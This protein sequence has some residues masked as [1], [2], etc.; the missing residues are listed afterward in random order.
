MKKIKFEIF[1]TD[2]FE[3]SLVCYFFISLFLYK[4]AY[5]PTQINTEKRSQK[6]INFLK[7]KTSLSFC[8]VFMNEG[9]ININ[10]TKIRP[11]IDNKTEV[12]DEEKSFINAK[13]LFGL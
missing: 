8:F 11:E 13:L 10:K 6:I 9:R 12:D 1:K 3:Y 2:I 5:T 4:Y 7:E